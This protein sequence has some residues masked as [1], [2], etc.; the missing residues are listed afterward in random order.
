MDPSSRAKSC[1]ASGQ[2]QLSGYDWRTD[3]VGGVFGRKGRRVADTFPTPPPSLCMATR[4][5][6]LLLTDAIW[7]QYLHF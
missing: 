3:C 4:D 7:V 2:A 1:L 5:L 6:R